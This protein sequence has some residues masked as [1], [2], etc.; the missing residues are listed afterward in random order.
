M[1]FTDISCRAI[2]AAAF[3]L[4][5]VRK[6]W[7]NAKP[8]QR[9]DHARTFRPHSIGKDEISARRWSAAI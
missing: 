2:A 4:S 9:L 6:D 7:L 8:G 5:P 1:N 3:S